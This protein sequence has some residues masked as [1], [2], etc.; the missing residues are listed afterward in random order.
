M[1]ADGW[2]KLIVPCHLGIVEAAAGRDFIDPDVGI[3]IN[4]GTI[5]VVDPSVDAGL[6][7]GIFEE[8]LERSDGSRV[9]RAAG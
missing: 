5:G 8:N 3:F 9:C 7:I 4:D 2:I 1:H 6:V